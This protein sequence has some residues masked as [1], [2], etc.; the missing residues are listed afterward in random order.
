MAIIVLMAFTNEDLAESRTELLLFAGIGIMAAS[1]ISAERSLKSVLAM[2]E[3]AVSVVG[4][5]LEMSHALTSS[6]GETGALTILVAA[7]LVAGVAIMF[8]SFD[9]HVVV[10]LL[11]TSTLGAMAVAGVT[12]VITV[13]PVLSPLG[14]HPPGQQ[15]LSTD[16]IRKPAP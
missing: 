10:R 16:T 14:V 12:L 7:G 3:A 2:A 1:A 13:V 4:A 6:G 11:V 15:P 8:V 9:A 5:Y